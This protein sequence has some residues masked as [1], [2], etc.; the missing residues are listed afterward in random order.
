[1][2]KV[3]DLVT[4]NADFAMRKYS[5]DERYELICCLSL[6][7]KE[8]VT[9]GYK[10][11]RYQAPQ[12]HE[13]SAA[14][15]F[16]DYLQSVFENFHEGAHALTQMKFSSYPDEDCALPNAV[17]D[18]A[19]RTLDGIVDS[20]VW[21]DLHSR[22][23]EE[24]EFFADVCTYLWL[25]LWMQIISRTKNPKVAALLRNAKEIAND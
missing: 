5:S 16:S 17:I 25:S 18:R 24:H 9:Y 4:V 11:P 21:Q 10:Y 6:A 22:V 1:M 14:F 7:V 23:W 12:S 2:L 13:W 3:K 8:F 19:H 20:P 15:P